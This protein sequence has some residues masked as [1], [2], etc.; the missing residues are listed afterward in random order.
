MYIDVVLVSTILMLGIGRFMV[1]YLSYDDVYV[2]YWWLGIAYVFVDCAYCRLPLV[3]FV[4]VYGFFMVRMRKFR[5]YG[6]EVMLEV[7]GVWAVGSSVL[8]G[9]A[10][11]KMRFLL[12]F[13]VP[14]LIGML[15]FVPPV[16][17]LM[18]L[19]S[20]VRK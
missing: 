9:Y 20:L 4:L 13:T 5:R 2:F 12:L 1:Y 16:C 7:L 3:L 14:G 8:F 10:M 17:L 18:M 6:S 19:V 15:G 11:L